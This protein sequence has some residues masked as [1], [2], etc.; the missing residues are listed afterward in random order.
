MPVYEIDA[1]KRWDADKRTSFTLRVKAKSPEHA[2]GKIGERDLVETRV[3]RLRGMKALRAYL[4]LD[5]R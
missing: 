1:Y 5:I 4:K 2:L 3:Q